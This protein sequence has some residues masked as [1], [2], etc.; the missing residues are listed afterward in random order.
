MLI[1]E[2]LR[3]LDEA[4]IATMLSFLRSQTSRGA[5]V[6]VVTPK[7]DEFQS[8]SDVLYR[9]DGGEVHPWSEKDSQQ[10]SLGVAPT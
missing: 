3:G 5:A 9:L 10:I 4:G 1:D 7:L 2:P 6:F 8:H